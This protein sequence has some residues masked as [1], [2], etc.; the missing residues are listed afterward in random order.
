MT[1]RVAAVRNM[2]LEPSRKAE[3]LERVSKIATREEAVAFVTEVDAKLHA[4]V[5][6]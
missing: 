1:V 2:A 5:P 4:L 6:Q 3:I